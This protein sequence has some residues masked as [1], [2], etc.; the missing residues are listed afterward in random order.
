MKYNILVVE[1]EKNILDVI[2][3]YL[4]KEDFN[5]FGADDGEIALE[6]FNNRNIHLIV[7]DLMI[8]KISGTEVCRLVREVSDIPI[9]MLTA[10]SDEE[11]KIINLSLGADDYMVKPFS[12]KELVSRVHALLRRSYKI[13]SLNP[14]SNLVIID[15]GRIRIDLDKMT[16]IKDEINIDFTANEFK[17]LS[18]MVLNPGMVLSRESL[19]EKAFGH[20][21]EGFD[22][23]IDTHIKNIRQKLEDN[24]KTPSYIQTVYGMGY[25]FEG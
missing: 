10:K 22:R 18:V 2:K 17:V 1:D 15:N 13:G 5:V 25:K 3:A 24:P 9:I 19:I 4:E 7:L 12:P 20:E 16:V 6:I 8:P 23:T 11:S 14:Q 21:Y